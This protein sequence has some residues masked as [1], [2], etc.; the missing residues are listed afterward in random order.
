MFHALSQGQGRLHIVTDSKYV[1]G[2]I[3]KVLAGAKLRG[4]HQDLWDAIGRFQDR[5]Q[6][7]TWVKAH[8]TWEEARARGIDREHWDLNRRADIE[9]G[10]GSTRT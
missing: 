2:G 10:E 9:A 4:K 1:A 5:I 7:V 3:T 8:L 6:G